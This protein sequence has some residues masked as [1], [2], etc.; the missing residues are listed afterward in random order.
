MKGQYGALERKYNALELQNTEDKK[1]LREFE[2]K[3]ADLTTALEKALKTA[4]IAKPPADDP[5][6]KEL[7]EQNGLL[8][9]QNRTLQEQSGDK[10]KAIADKDRAIAD[11]QEQNARLLNTT[12]EQ[13]LQT[14]LGEVYALTQQLAIIDPDQADNLKGHADLFASDVA[15]LRELIY[16][17]LATLQEHTRKDKG[18]GKGLH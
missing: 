10:D 9:E 17:G 1:T 3:I 7:Q 5:A 11:L 15:R 13:A 16:Q 6:F 12:Q 14:L 2:G 8:Q 4:P 18:G